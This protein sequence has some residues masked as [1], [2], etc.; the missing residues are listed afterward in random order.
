MHGRGV[1]MVA[2]LWQRI[3]I[4][5]IIASLSW[6]LELRVD[7]WQW[8]MRFIVI[9]PKPET[10]AYVVS[11]ARDCQR[12]FTSSIFRFQLFLT[13]SL[14]SLSLS[15]FFSFLWFTTMCCFTRRRTNRKGSTSITNVEAHAIPATTRLENIMQSFMV[16]ASL[17]SKRIG[18]AMNFAQRKTRERKKWNKANRKSCE[19]MHLNQIWCT[20]GRCCIIHAFLFLQHEH[21]MNGTHIS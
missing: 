2:H 14:L 15:V 16:L 8:A 3:T 4:M 12:P 11:W 9:V 13:R 6:Q 21:E 7:W 19:R 5:I 17:S 20:H 18:L 1:G 10:Y